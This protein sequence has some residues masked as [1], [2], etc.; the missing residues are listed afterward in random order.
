MSVEI[1]TIPEHIRAQLAANS[2][3]VLLALN[4]WRETAA[5]TNEL[6]RYN[7]ER[8]ER[9]STEE[10]GAF[11]GWE[12]VMAAV[13][14]SEIV[15]T[16]L[17][18]MRD[19]AASPFHAADNKALKALFDTLR[20][21]AVSDAEVRTLLR[22]RVPP[23][24]GT[25]AVRVAWVQTKLVRTFQL[26]I[27]ETAR[28]WWTHAENARWWRHLPMSLT[29]EESLVVAPV[30]D[31]DRDA[32]LAEIEATPERI[33]TLARMD[34]QQ[35]AFEHTALRHGDVRGARGLAS[36]ASQIVINIIANASPTGAPASD[37]RRLFPFL[38]RDL[39]PIEKKVLVDD[40]HY[41]LA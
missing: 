23:G 35:R 4:S 31:Q 41:T 5:A 8:M 36:V 20:S 15:G 11:L 17:L 39:T 37:E 30:A 25:N 6:V 27:K 32:V 3:F 29:W 14:L 16:V 18:H 24:F 1:L 13:E 40:G 9:A 7:F 10:E 34:E 2:D 26:A 12:I 33:E 38:T 28:F 22:L 21:G 19:R